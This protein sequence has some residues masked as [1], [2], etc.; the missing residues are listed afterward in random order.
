VRFPISR[1]L[2]LYVRVISFR[3]YKD[4]SVD[5]LLFS[6][7]LPTSV[8]FKAVARGVRCDLGHESWSEIA[9]VA[10]GLHDGKNCM[11]LQSLVLTHYQLITERDKN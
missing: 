3:R 1:P 5:N 10:D 4:L 2:Q 11:I 9:R 7:F 6:P 8:S